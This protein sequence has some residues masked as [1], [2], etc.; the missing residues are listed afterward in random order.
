VRV[1]FNPDVTIEEITEVLTKAGRSVVGGP[2]EDDQ[3]LISRRAYDPRML[4]DLL[5][6]LGLVTPNTCDSGDLFDK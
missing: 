5:G 4:N 3:Y 1:K 2:V 6:G